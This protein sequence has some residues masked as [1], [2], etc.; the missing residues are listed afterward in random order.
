MGTEKKRRKL[1]K[2]EGLS[3]GTENKRRKLNKKESSTCVLDPLAQT[4]TETEK[5]SRR[6]KK[7]EG[8]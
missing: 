8:D 4:S 2:K 5:K 3:Q 6:L 1:K 7:K